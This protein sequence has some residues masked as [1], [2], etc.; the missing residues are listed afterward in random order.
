MVGLTSTPTVLADPGEGGGIMRI[1]Q[2]TVETSAAD[3]T[4][5][6]YLIA[7]LPSNVRISNLSR[8]HNDA[9]GS[10]TTTLDIGV[11]NTSSAVSIITNDDDA[12]NAGVVASTAG[13][14]NLLADFA[15]GGK[16]LWEFVNGQTTDPKCDLDVKLTLKTANL[17]SGA[18]TISVDIVYAYD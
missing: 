14:K 3:S 16:R 1:W 12:L 17:S 7:R 4:T 8:I 5:S 15:N 13:T 18:G 2:E 9:L 10:T 6:T 11:F